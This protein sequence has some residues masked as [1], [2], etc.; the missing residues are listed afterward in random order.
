MSTNVGSVA[1]HFPDAENG[2]TTTTSGSVA[3]GASTVGL[4]SV[5]GYTNGQPAVFVI[6][7]TSAT[8][9][10][11]FTGIIDTSGVQVTSVVW[12]AGTNQTHA[13][14]VTVV[15]YATATHIAMISKGLLVEHTQAGRHTIGS[16]STLTSTK[17][18]TDLSD[19]NG[20][21]LIKV[22]A[23]GSAVN[24]VTLANAATGNNP[25][26]TASGGDTNV[27]MRLQG[28]GT[29]GVWVDE[30]QPYKFRAYKSSAGNMTNGSNAKIVLAGE[31]FDT[32]SNFDSATNY[33]YTAPVAGFYY[34]NGKIEAN[35]L[36]A[37]TIQA[38]LYKNGSKVVSGYQNSN[39]TGATTFQQTSVTAFIQLA[40][41]DY[42]ELYGISNATP[43]MSTSNDATFLEG[44]LV[45]RT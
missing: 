37:T 36:N 43:S 33:R 42:I 6:E 25:S 39:N 21:E 40:A 18:I 13:L 31:D 45:S 2:F 32:N 34:F 22:T 28:K 15:D 27:T 29:G 8:A 5:A 24:E 14:G 35:C 10:Q 1:S 12:T 9:K 4:N 41:N 30:Y 38:N 16:S 7:P 19:T 20:N 3:S 23:T 17:V 44:F 26:I 11:T